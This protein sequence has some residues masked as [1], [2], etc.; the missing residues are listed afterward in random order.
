MSVILHVGDRRGLVQEVHFQRDSGSHPVISENAQLAGH[1]ARTSSIAR[2]SR[3]FNA[4]KNRSIQDRLT[5]RKTPVI[6][7]MLDG[8]PWGANAKGVFT[9]F[10]AQVS[11]NVED[12]S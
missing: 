5:S 11:P 9:G 3:S 6:C 1:N 10:G 8:H 2:V 12:T 7:K 4:R